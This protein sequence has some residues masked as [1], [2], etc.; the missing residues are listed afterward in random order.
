EGGDEA[1]AL[2]WCGVA[3]G[4]Q[5]EREERRARHLVPWVKRV[6]RAVLRVGGGAA[7]CRWDDRRRGSRHR[8]P[9]RHSARRALGPTFTFHHQSR[10]R[11][12]HWRRRQSLREPRTSATGGR[13]PGGGSAPVLGGAGVADR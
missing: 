11:A 4:E 6:S 7:A 2:G 1:I 3:A 9:A 8:P 5:E 13:A 10:A 12:R